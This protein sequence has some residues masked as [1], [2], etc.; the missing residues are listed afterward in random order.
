MS[1]CTKLPTAISRA[2]TRELSATTTEL[3]RETIWKEADRDVALEPAG[4]LPF[5]LQYL[6]NGRT[7]SETVEDCATENLSRQG[8]RP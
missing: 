1:M 3:G 6:K 4:E 5:T 2:P 8:S 7:A